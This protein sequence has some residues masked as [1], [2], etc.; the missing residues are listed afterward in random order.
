MLVQQAALHFVRRPALESCQAQQAEGTGSPYCS[1]GETVA[2]VRV[3]VK[4]TDRDAA[5]RE[6]AAYKRLEELQGVHLPR[7]LAFGDTLGGTAFLAA[8]EYLQVCRGCPTQQAEP[9]GSNT[10]KHIIACQS[11]VCPDVHSQSV[12]RG[13]P[14]HKVWWQG[15]TPNSQCRPCRVR[16]GYPEDYI[17]HV[18]T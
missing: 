10:S 9:V 18:C 12:L 6:V 15:V 11:S 5:E 4:A 8:I 2:A 7:L 17:A 3:A 16:L 13:C 1:V 14:Y